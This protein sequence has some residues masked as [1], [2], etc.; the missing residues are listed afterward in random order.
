MTSGV[1]LQPV[2]RLVL[3]TDRL[4]RERS[5]VR[6]GSLLEGLTDLWRSLQKHQTTQLQTTMLLLFDFPNE[7]LHKI[8]DRVRP[9]DFENFT[10]SCKF[11]RKLAGKRLEHHRLF[12]QEL[13]RVHS[14]SGAFRDYRLP[15]LLDRFLVEPRTADYIDE[16]LVQGWHPCWEQPL[17]GED[18]IHRRYLDGRMKAFEK[19]VKDTNSIPSADKEDWISK[20]HA[21][22]ED[23]LISLLVMQLH[24]LTNIK[25]ELGN[26]I[27]VLFETMKSIVKDPRSLSLSQLRNVEIYGNRPNHHMGLAVCFAALPS[28]VSLTAR[29][30][31]EQALGSKDNSFNLSPHS[32]SVR[33]LTLDRC[34][35]SIETMSILIASIRSLRS[36]RCDNYRT[37]YDPSFANM[38]TI[39]QQHASS[40]L[41]EVSILSD[42]E[43][44]NFGSYTK[45]RVLTISYGLFCKPLTTDV[46]MTFLPASLEI[47]NIFGH[48]VNSFAWFQAMIESFVSMKRRK[49]RGLRQLNF[50]E[51]LLMHRG[52]PSQMRNLYL[53]AARAGIHLNAVAY[54]LNAFSRVDLAANLRRR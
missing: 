38:L 19:G 27:S 41:E 52:S 15:E 16:L 33:D 36:F 39:L 5:F 51:K 48:H 23:P 49:I 29:G 9:R 12:K 14:G 25:M 43:G 53:E 10:L 37:E 8:L 31:N 3:N 7:I 26:N 22:D 28:V 24:C 40:S 47:L 30:L 17:E 2:E 46:M 21:G 18:D 45:L 50:K 35:F 20:I 13:S 4:P 6:T 34:T 1:W 44:S 32:S 42:S 54:H 11:I